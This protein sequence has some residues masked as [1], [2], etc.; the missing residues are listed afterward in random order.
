MKNKKVLFLTQ[1]A[2][3]AALYV[4]LTELSNLFGLASSM[5]QVRFSEALTVLPFFTP[6]AVPGLFLGCI[7]SN[8]LVNANIFDI[9]FG[10]LATLLGALGTMGLGKL[11]CIGR[12]TPE[13]NN[14]TTPKENNSSDGNQKK[15]KEKPILL[16]LLTL[17]PIL[18]NTL[19][20]PFVLKYA[21]GLEPLW[22]SFI[23]V[24]LG[25]I[26]SCGVFGIVLL[27]TLRKYG[28]RIF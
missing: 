13:E 2:L 10:S 11:L 16:S 28:K 15:K 25:E 26:I 20:I 14:G 3:I 24:G 17:P 8:L 23:T 21:Y 7:I 22:L 12:K 4:V 18:S 1:A 27:F 6:A 5:I 19:I 9:I